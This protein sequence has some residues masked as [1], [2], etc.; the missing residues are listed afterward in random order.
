MD[1]A[2]KQ[3]IAGQLRNFGEFAQGEYIRMS[4]ELEQDEYYVDLGVFGEQSMS[5]N[6]EE[7]DYQFDAD[8]VL[9]RYPLSSQEF[10]DLAEELEND[11]EEVVKEL[12]LDSV[13]AQME[14]NGEGVLATALRTT[15]QAFQTALREAKEQ[16]KAALSALMPLPPKPLP[17]PG[18]LRD[19]I[20]YTDPQFPLRYQPPPGYDW[21]RFGSSSAESWQT[22]KPTEATNVLATGTNMIMDKAGR[23][24]WTQRAEDDLTSGVRW[25][26]WFLERDGI[27]AGTGQFTS[28]TRPLAIDTNGDVIGEWKGSNGDTA[29]WDDSQI[30][31]AKRRVAELRA[32]Q[33][34]SSSVGISYDPLTVAVS[35]E[36]V[37]VETTELRLGDDITGDGYG[38]VTSV[39]RQSV[40]GYMITMNRD[41][42]INTIRNW[43]GNTEWSVFPIVGVDRES[44][45]TAVSLSQ[46]AQGYDPLTVPLK[47]EEAF[48]ASQDLRLGDDILGD[49]FGRVVSIENGEIVMNRDGK[50]NR[51]MYRETLK[52]LIKMIDV[53]N[54]ENVPTAAS[55]QAV[56]A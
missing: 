19:D 34:L 7:S 36:E 40:D 53:P 56:A 10:I 45:P 30:E 5:V 51:T 47:A 12:T 23:V 31:Q 25:S 33:Q 35:D 6:L 4:V 38:R 48:I 54:R 29:V 18:A 49:S 52:W 17:W 21:T 1:K 43:S 37:S 11:D 46:G 27:P 24:S 26:L 28:S 22:V 42:R 16:A 8:D 13:L 14:Q 9:E 44:Q 32:E 50:E 15:A 3:E 2:R 39:Q 55:L 41:G 20:D